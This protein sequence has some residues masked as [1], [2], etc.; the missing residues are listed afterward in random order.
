MGKKGW[1]ITTSF[2]GKIEELKTGQVLQVFGRHAQIAKE[3][4]I[5]GN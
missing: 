3:T 5:V 1:M 2:T 4:G